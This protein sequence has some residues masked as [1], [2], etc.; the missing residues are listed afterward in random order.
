[1][2]LRKSKRR[3][4]KGLAM[5]TSL[6][7][8][9]KSSTWASSTINTWIDGLASFCTR[10]QASRGEG[11]KRNGGCRGKAYALDPG[12]VLG[13]EGAAI[14]HNHAAWAQIGEG[15][16]LNGREVHEEGGGEK[17]EGGGEG[18]RDGQ[19]SVL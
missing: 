9:R 14:A 1:M 18:D 8:K 16:Q 2:L 5:A 15:V 7:A 4:S 3:P 11:R 6:G 10:G 13:G 19:P 12:H 17:V